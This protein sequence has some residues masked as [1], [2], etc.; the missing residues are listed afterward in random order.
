MRIR[1]QPCHCAEYIAH[2]ARA[3]STVANASRA[4]A[5]R[6]HT[7]SYPNQWVRLLS[8]EHYLS[9]LHQLGLIHAPDPSDAFRLFYGLVIQDAQIQ[10]LLGAPRLTASERRGR[11]ERAVDHFLILTTQATRT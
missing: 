2:T 9:R 8:I 10:G 4:R 5:R 3:S 7:T 11:A 6:H 1:L